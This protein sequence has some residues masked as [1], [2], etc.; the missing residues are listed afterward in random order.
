[1]CASGSAATEVID[2]L[3]LALDAWAE[4]LTFQMHSSVFLLEIAKRK[5]GQTGVW[6]QDLLE[7]HQ[8]L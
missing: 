1:M 8:V 5:D 6:T 4:A 3:Q 2:V 7:L